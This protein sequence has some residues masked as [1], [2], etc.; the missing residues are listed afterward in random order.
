MYN[1]VLYTVSFQLSHRVCNLMFHGDAKTAI[2]L[3]SEESPGSVLSL[4]QEIDGKSVKD[5]LVEKYPMLNH[6]RLRPC[7]PL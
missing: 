2:R 1:Y 3:L 4:S 6:Y 7:V 5:L